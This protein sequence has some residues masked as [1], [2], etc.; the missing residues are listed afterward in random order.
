MGG[1]GRR[2]GPGAEIWAE[3]KEGRERWNGLGQ[4]RLREIEKFCIFFENDPNQFN[5]NSNSTEFKLEL[6]NKQWN[7][8]L[9]HECNTKE[10]PYLIIKNKQS[11]FF[12][13]K[14]SVKTISVEQFF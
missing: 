5:S 13:T 9:R 6:N 8:A 3:R 2:A 7:N 1:R 12:Y 4:E 11:I 14:F 10:Q